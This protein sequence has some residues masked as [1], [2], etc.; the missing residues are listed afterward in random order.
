MLIVSMCPEMCKFCNEIN[1]SV[2]L[3]VVSGSFPKLNPGFSVQVCFD[4]ELKFLSFKYRQVTCHLIP[5]SLSFYYL[6]VM[7]CLFNSVDENSPYK[8]CDS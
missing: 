6:C 7:H 5:V 8:V 1:Q 4:F 3:A 2:T